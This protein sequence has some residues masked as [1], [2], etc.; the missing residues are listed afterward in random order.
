MLK[1]VLKTFVF[2]FL[3][4]V[5]KGKKTSFLVALM[6]VTDIFHTNSFLLH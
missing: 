2:P 3:P 5:F 6:L 1:I 4:S